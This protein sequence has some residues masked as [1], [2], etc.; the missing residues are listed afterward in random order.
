M[1]ARFV[2]PNRSTS[3]V[4]SSSLTDALLGTIADRRGADAFVR[5]APAPGSDDHDA[6]H[7]L[8]DVGAS[9][10]AGL[11]AH[12]RA[13][14]PLCAPT[15]NAYAR[16]TV[17]ATAWLARASIERQRDLFRLNLFDFL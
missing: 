6:S 1:S 16:A 7:T 4:T 17:G 3:A 13:A 15:L 11:L 8:S 2:V 14:A 5:A 10:L 12:A 9:Y